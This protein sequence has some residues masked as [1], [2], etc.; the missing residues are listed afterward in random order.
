MKDVE[1]RYSIQYGEEVDKT[2]REMYA[3]TGSR[4]T[5]TASTN[6]LI[7]MDTKGEQFGIDD[8]FA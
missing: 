1:W 2:I 4:S 6:V 5:S 3:M 7:T 8:L